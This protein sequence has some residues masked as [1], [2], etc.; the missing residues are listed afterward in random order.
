MNTTKEKSREIIELGR[1]N[2]G[3]YD[4]S[5]SVSGSQPS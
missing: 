5:F 1:H 2:I 3:T 4:F